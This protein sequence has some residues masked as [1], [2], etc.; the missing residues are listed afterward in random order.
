MTALVEVCPPD[1]TPEPT[2]TPEP[3]KPP[4]TGGGDVGPLFAGTMAVV[5]LLGLGAGAIRY[6]IRKEG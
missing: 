1:P 3:K 6:F 2:A 4:D 5:G